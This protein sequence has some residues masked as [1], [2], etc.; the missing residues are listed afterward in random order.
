VSDRQFRCAK[1]GGEFTKGWLDE[2]AAAEHARNFPEVG[3]TVGRVVVCDPCYLAFLRW[4]D[5]H[6]EERHSHGWA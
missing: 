1:C 5:E 3:P 4:L 2:E 6:P